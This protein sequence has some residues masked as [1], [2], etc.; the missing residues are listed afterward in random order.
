[1]K[2]VH[3]IASFLTITSILTVKL[4][5]EP[6]SMTVE[7]ALTSYT[8]EVQIDSGQAKEIHFFADGTAQGWGLWHWIAT[9]PRAFNINGNT[10]CGFD[11]SFSHFIGHFTE[12][13]REHTTTGVRL[14][15]VAGSTPAAL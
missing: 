9:G 15:L 5:A 3:L 6:R 12:R 4:A 7:Q 10:L 2:S 11:D 13:G 1:M 8:W 14:G